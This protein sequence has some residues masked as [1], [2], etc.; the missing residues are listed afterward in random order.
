M[1]GGAPPA[2]DTTGDTADV[3]DA[4]AVLLDDAEQ[5]F[6]AEVVAAVRAMPGVG[7]RQYFAGRDGATRELYQA[8]GARGWLTLCWP[9][10]HGGRA[11]PRSYEFLLWDTLAYLRAARPDLGPGLIAHLVIHHGSPQLQ[12]QVLPGLA[13]GSLAMCLGYSEPDAGS[14]L[15]HLKTTA[16]R[17]GDTYVVRGH[18]IWTSEAHHAQKM[19]LLCR[20][21]EQERG[22]RGLSLFVL[23]MDSPGLTVSPIPTIDGHRINEVFLDDVVVPATN[24]VGEEGGAWPMMRAGLAVERHTQVLPGRLR[25]DIETLEAALAAE[26]IA[27]R[28]HVRSVVAELRARLGTVEAISLATVAELDAGSDAVS[29]AAQAKLLGSRLCQ[30]VPRAGLELLGNAAAL[31]DGELAFL[32]R[33]SVMETIAGGTVEVMSSL[34]ARGLGLRSTQ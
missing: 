6:R 2:G 29:L 20:T 30:D 18:K 7:P 11:A 3:P 31:G 10:E 24:L 5:R 32:W 17:D 22:N 14:D 12:Q 33:Q 15:T 1:H 4:Y 28:S 25:R 27:T 23:D 26:G 19:W 16:R 9:A 8:L 34:V 21:G 13:A